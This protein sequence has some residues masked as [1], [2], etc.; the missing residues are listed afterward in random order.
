MAGISRSVFVVSFASR[1]AW[2]RYHFIFDRSPASFRELLNT[3]CRF[4]RDPDL[5]FSWDDCHTL[6]DAAREL[7]YGD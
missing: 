2:H 6:A 4:A 1:Y 7:M 3:L 5:P